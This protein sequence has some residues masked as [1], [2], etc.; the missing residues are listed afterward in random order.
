MR[1]K[2]TFRKRGRLGYTLVELMVTM[3]V[4]GVLAAVSIT[5]LPRMKL[6]QRISRSARVFAGLVRE[7]RGRSVSNRVF[8]RIEATTGIAGTIEISQWRCEFG[9]LSPVA[10]ECA[11]TDWEALRSYTM[12]VDDFSRVMLAGTPNGNGAGITATIVWSPQGTVVGGL[13]DGVNGTYFFREAGDFAGSRAQT[14]GCS[15]SGTGQVEVR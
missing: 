7:A 5:N 11:G 3:G 13:T 4:I 9:T 6:N 12:G 2:Y 8:T 15:V 10:A 1:A 14:W